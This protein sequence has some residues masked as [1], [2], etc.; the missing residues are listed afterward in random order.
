M[1]QVPSDGSL[2]FY[3]C[4]AVMTVPALLAFPELAG[5]VTQLSCH[6]QAPHIVGLQRETKQHHNLA[7]GPCSASLSHCVMN[8][9]Y[10]VCLHCCE[11]HAAV[12]NHALWQYCGGQQASR[13][14]VDHLLLCVVLCASCVQLLSSFFAKVE[15]PRSHWASL[16]LTEQPDLCQTVEG[17]ELFMCGASC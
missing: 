10:S 17:S 3:V 8:F 2:Y 9:P 1:Q 4:I 11:S 6:K 13:V 14:S 5:T 12:S 7:A 15:A 16:N